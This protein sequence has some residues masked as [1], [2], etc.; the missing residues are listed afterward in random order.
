[1]KDS[2]EILVELVQ[3]T[4]FSSHSHVVENTV[5][6]YQ[7]IREIERGLIASVVVA[8]KLGAG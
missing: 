2:I 8:T 1:M 5:V 3:F 6:K 4:D 7:L